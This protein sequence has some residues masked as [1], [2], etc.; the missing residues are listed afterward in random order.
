MTLNKK[1]LY[2]RRHLTMNETTHKDAFLVF[3][4]AVV[5]SPDEKPM[6]RELAYACNP[7]KK[8]G[9][10]NKRIEVWRFETPYFYRQLSIKQKRKEEEA[11]RKNHGMKFKADDEER[12]HCHQQFEV[13]SIVKKAWREHCLAS[14]GNDVLVVYSQDV[15]GDMLRLLEIPCKHI[16]DLCGYAEAVAFDPYKTNLASVKEAMT[17]RLPHSFD[18]PCQATIAMRLALFVW[19]SLNG[20]RQ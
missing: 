3:S 7:Y 15:V 19:T 14:D 17:C 4:A 20:K 8:C 9:E 11:R 2:T 1:G 16:N 5:H 18:C 12:E 6:F 10:G 13:Y